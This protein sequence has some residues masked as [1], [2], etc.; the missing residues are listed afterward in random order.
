LVATVVAVGFE[1]ITCLKKNL[2]LRVRA[3]HG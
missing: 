3:I 1:N 2:R